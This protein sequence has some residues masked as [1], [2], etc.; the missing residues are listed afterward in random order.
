VRIV[1]LATCF[2]LAGCSTTASQLGE[3]PERYSIES[4]L[5]PQHIADCIARE[6]PGLYVPVTNGVGLDRSVV[7]RQEPLGAVVL[8][9]IKATSSGSSV[10]IRSVTKALNGRIA[11]L[12]HCYR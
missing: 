12:A 2:I 10:A 6:T 1:T 8:F 5:D 11:K 3:L 4:K 9:D 7:W